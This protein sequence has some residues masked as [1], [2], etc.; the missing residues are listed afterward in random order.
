MSTPALR[1][2]N[3]GAQ[4]SFAASGARLSEIFL[5]HT[6]NVSDKWE[7]YLAIYEAEL[8][9]FV[10]TGQPVRLLEI[11][12][13][14]GG[15]L[16]IWSRYL[17]RGSSIAGID[18]DPACATLA[19]PPN[20]RVLIGDASDPAVLDRLLG[21][22]QFDVIVDDGSHRSDHII[23]SFAACFPR[24][25][26]GGLY[27]VE[28]LHCSY[29]ASFG[30]GFRKPGA[31]VEHFKQLADA[32]N[33]DHFESDAEAAD[34]NETGQLRAAG[35]EIARITFYDSVVVVEKLAVPKTRPYRRV[36]TGST[37]PTTDLGQSFGAGMTAPELRNMVLAPATVAAFDQS[38]RD[39]LAA[40]RDAA[41]AQREAAA[42]HAQTAE[43]LRVEVAEQHA[44]REAERNAQAQAI[45]RLRAA[46]ASLDS[47][48]NRLHVRLLSLDGEVDRL[49]AL[50]ATQQAEI[51]ELNG[52]A[53]ALRGEL[54][55]ARAALQRTQTHVAALLSSTSWRIT[56]P[57]RALVIAARD[58]AASARMLT[59]V[60]A[61]TR[62]VIARDGLVTCVRRA[63][64]VLRR[65][66]LSGFVRA[67]L[68]RAPTDAR[69]ALP[70]NAPPPRF[71]RQERFLP[72]RDPRLDPFIFD[73]NLARATAAQQ[74]R[75]SLRM[76]PQPTAGLSVVILTRDKPELILPLLDSLIA[77]RPAFTAR[78]L[79]L[80]VLV[81]DTGSTDP[82]VLDG[83]AAR[84]DACVIVRDLAYQFSRTNN[85]VALRAEHEVLL[86]LNNDVILGD[87]AATTLA[88]HDV[89]ATGGDATVAGLVMQFGDGER[90]Q[91]GGV[92]FFRAGPLRALPFHPRAHEKRGPAAF[93]PRSEVPAVTG[94]CL[95]IRADAFRRIGG[96]DTRYAAECQDIDL[97]L[98]ARRIGGRCIL[99][100]E[101]QPL[102]LE[103]ATRPR[104]EE[105]F[106][107]RRLFIRR[108]TAWLEATGQVERGA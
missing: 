11:G 22:A 91:H 76:R 95:A 94:A 45:E 13:Q 53:D 52:A 20:A 102:H 12:V 14:N 78:G 80:Q 84:E 30:G 46:Q 86:F 104:G 38:L 100:A 17:P 96:F 29:A 51:R 43:A 72:E 75:P 5:A 107:D 92:D 6:G 81:G 98:K 71:T 15:S 39:A 32:L 56:A 48:V 58:P 60:A 89:V 36:I 105:N 87:A 73:D 49:R 64:G 66:G 57:L 83:Y 106:A 27:V 103:N 35:Q 9:R 67:A 101:G 25:A 23:A 33:A 85:T 40:E 79:G 59:S 90:L 99:V 41:H 44:E 21:S 88:L 97:C 55:H 19:V 16:E 65:D 34:A 50:E 4:P 8:S 77:A 3:S 62:R 93:P 26:P 2:T 31:A 10:A 28:D 61:K 42:A 68:H 24:L 69:A 70:A 63:T 7:Q 54:H 18:V 74:L 108:W 47:E 37:Q 1:E 82:A